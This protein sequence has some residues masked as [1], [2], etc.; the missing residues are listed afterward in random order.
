LCLDFVDARKGGLGLIQMRIVAGERKLDL[1]AIGKALE[2]N[3]EAGS[4][5]L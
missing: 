4:G 5:G 1:D 3:L 2:E